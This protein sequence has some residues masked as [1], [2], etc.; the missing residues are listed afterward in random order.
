MS[1]SASQA[2]DE[3]SAHIRKIIQQTLIGVGLAADNVA[4]YGRGRPRIML[5]DVRHKCRSRDSG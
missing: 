5:L 3:R 4:Q 2:L 1:A